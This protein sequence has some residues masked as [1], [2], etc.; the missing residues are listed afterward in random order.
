MNNF[1]AEALESY[2]K[3]GKIA[4]T[5][6]EYGKNIIKEGASAFESV[7]KIERSILD[8]GG[9]LAFP[10]NVSANDE[11]AH[12]TPSYNDS[13]LFNKGDLIKLDLGVHI[14]GYIADTAITVEVGSNNNDFLIT[15]SK[16]ALENVIK[17]IHAGIEFSEIGA[18]IEDSIKF[19]EY[20]PIYNLNGHELSK[21]KL[22][23]GKTVPNYNN[24]DHT[25]L[26]VGTAIA[27]EPF[28]TTGIG[29]I[30]EHNYGGIAMLK[31]PPKKDEFG[32]YNLL[33][34]KFNGLPFAERWLYN[35]VENY[36]KVMEWLLKNG[37][38][39]KFPILKEKKRGLV[40][41]AEHTFLVTANG[42]IVTT[43]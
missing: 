24:K 39:Y 9:N 26:E 42:I 27:I 11:A 35:S 25:R 22:H 2:I 21:F 13:R 43:I 10:V 14:N 37:N 1:T 8:S 12:Y 6:I 7:T 34:Q 18:V 41:Q 40:S 3:A 36:N 20:K 30:K 32:Y 33:F 4:K 38:L 23:S 28:A 5:A 29:L 16:K 31:D 17:E 15:S 19:Y